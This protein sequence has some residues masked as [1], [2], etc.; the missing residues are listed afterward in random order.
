VSG[1]FIP[2]KVMNMDYIKIA[3][4][5]EEDIKRY[6]RLIAKEQ[7][8]FSVTKSAFEKMSINKRIKFYRHLI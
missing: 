1:I 8:R 6:E 4:D 7:K 5:Y 2:K 3:E